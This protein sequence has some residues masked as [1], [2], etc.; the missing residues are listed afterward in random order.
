LS[1]VEEAL[2]LQVLDF[3]E[4]CSALVCELDDFCSET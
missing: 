1:S 2:F 4:V 3:E